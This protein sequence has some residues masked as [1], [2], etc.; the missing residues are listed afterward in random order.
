MRKII[1]A[2]G[3]CFAPLLAWSQ[4]Y[5]EAS[6]SLSKLSIDC[7]TNN[8]CDSKLSGYRLLV[9][10]TAP[11]WM[12]LDLDGGA[13]TDGIEVGYARYGSIKASGIVRKRI[14]NG[15]GSSVLAD[16]EVE[17]EI[18]ADAVFAHWVG[19]MPVDLDGL[20]LVAKLGMAYVSSTSEYTERG[21]SM[22]GSTHSRFSP[23]VGL[24]VEYKVLDELSLSLGYEG[25]RFKVD[26]QS[27]Y[28]HGLNFGLQVRY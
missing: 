14:S 18:S 27:G 19:R 2:T 22:G 16:V 26:S 11:G 9:G 10:A 20:N 12:Q 24:G 17:N 21:V 8:Q 4:S 1:L 6:Y 25:L 5:F 3:L 7:A 13:K 15:T 23:A 28:V